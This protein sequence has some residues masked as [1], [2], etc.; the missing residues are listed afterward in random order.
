[1]TSTER[2]TISRTIKAPPASVFAA[3]T[4]PEL[5]RQWYGP[6]AGPVLS[7]NIDACPGGSFDIS[8]QLE[9]GT[10]FRT[11]G[12]Y[13][14]VSP[15]HRLV[16]TLTWDGK[17]QETSKVSIVISPDGDGSVMEFSQEQLPSKA[18]LTGQHEGWNDAFEKLYRVLEV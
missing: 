8:V 14:E 18:G 13:L 17:P 3:W 12:D 4:D 1:M 15:P 2:F 7:A 16:F 11:T 10:V 6:D 9:N 5:L